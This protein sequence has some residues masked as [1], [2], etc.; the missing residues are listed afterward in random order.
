METYAFR[1]NPGQD[2]KKE[3]EVLTKSEKWGAACVLSGV[4]SLSKAAIRF[5]NKNSAEIL[6]GPLEIISLNG[7]LSQDGL[8]LHI[9]VS[10]GNGKVVGGHL[11]E[12]SIIFTTA[13]I[14]S[15]ILNGWKF[16]RSDDPA[17]G[18]TE[19]SVTHE[20]EGESAGRSES[21]G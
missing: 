7:T 10:D 1:L 20:G 4:G 14:V 2:L 9:S 17:T 3:M 19:L 18:F 11:M 21:N 15:G 16:T 5:A 8:H 6:E 13:E 12:G